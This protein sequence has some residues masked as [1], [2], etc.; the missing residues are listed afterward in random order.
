M[1]KIIFTVVLY[2]L[3]LALFVLCGYL[4]YLS[5]GAKPSN[6]IFVLLGILAFPLSSV[7]HELG[8]AL[9][10]LFVKI[11]AVPEFKFRGSSSCKI[12]P[13]TLKNIKARVIFTTVGGLF[14]NFALTVIGIIALAVP[15]VPVWLCVAL[16]ASF[17][18]FALNILPLGLDE[19]TD[20]EVIYELIKETDSAKV[21][22]AVLTIQA[23]ICCGEAISELDEDLFFN[24]PQICEDD[25]NFIALTQM[26]YEY[27]N[28]KGDEINAEKY[29]S[30]YE[31]LKKEYL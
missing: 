11:K 10:G 1:K 16:P 22:L 2:V 14:V 13:K 4:I 28:A 9:F 17:Y 24:V 26:R 18:L 21:M 3:S 6:V 27:F 25:I 7:L 15:A 19:R 31:E 8:H 20:G 29:K 5:Y 30:R 12:I 23:H